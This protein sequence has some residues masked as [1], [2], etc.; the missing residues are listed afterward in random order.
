M[1]SRQ[2]RVRACGQRWAA[3]SL[4]R[5]LQRLSRR[6]ERT[7]LTGCAVWGQLEPWGASWVRE[8]A[9]GAVRCGDRWRVRAKKLAT[10]AA[11]LERGQRS[12]AGLTA[13]GRLRIKIARE[14]SVRCRWT[15]SPGRHGTIESREIL[16][17]VGAGSWERTGA[18]RTAGPG[19]TAQKQRREVQRRR[20]KQLLARRAGGGQVPMSAQVSPQSKFSAV[21]CSAVQ[22]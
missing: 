6:R 2:R 3:C 5:A 17:R 18:G 1:L 11:V 20:R 7:H 19:R 12:R 4:C 22:C 14:T 15:R 13:T 21:E 8:S 16:E 9:G 10:D